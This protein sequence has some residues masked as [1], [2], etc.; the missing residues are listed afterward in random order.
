MTPKP[1]ELIEDSQRRN[2]DMPPA[3]VLTKLC[4]IT[5]YFP[6]YLGD[7][8][9]L[10]ITEEMLAYFSR[11]KLK[12]T[13]KDHSEENE[14]SVVVFCGLKDDIDAVLTS[15][16]NVIQKKIINYN[17]DL[18]F[19]HENRLEVDVKFDITKELGVKTVK[20]KKSVWIQHVLKGGQF[21]QIFD[22]RLQGGAA[23]T[24]MGLMKSNSLEPIFSNK[25]KNAF[26]ARAKG[27]LD[28]DHCDINKWII[29]RICLLNDGNIDIDKI[30]TSNSQIL[31]HSKRSSS[32]FD[33]KANR[34]APLNHKTGEKKSKLNVESTITCGSSLSKK[35]KLP[36]PP[37]KDPSSSISTENLPRKKLHQGEKNILSK[38]MTDKDTSY[39]H[40]RDKTQPVRE[41]E[42]KNRVN[43]HAACGSMWMQHKKLFGDH[44]DTNCNC[45]AEMDKLVKN[46]VTGGTSSDSGD[47]V[48]FADSFC[49]K[50]FDKVQK[51]FPNNSA[52]QILLKLVD[53]WKLGHV[54]Q[55]TLGAMCDASCSCGN[56]WSL[57]FLPI[58]RGDLLQ[59]D[60]TKLSIHSSAEACCSDENIF[61]DITFRPSVSS[62]GFYC[63]THI[64]DESKPQCIVK[65]V[66]PRMKVVS[67]LTPGTIVDCYILGKETVKVST[68]QQLERV[69]NVLKTRGDKSPLTIRFKKVKNSHNDGNY[70]CSRDWSETN[71]WI[72]ELSKQGW[73]GGAMVLKGGKKLNKGTRALAKESAKALRQKEKFLPQSAK[74]VIREVMKGSK[75][76]SL[77]NS[78]RTR[79]GQ[80]ITGALVLTHRDRSVNVP[81][82]TFQKDA[83]PP[84]SGSLLP[85]KKHS[86]YL[87]KHT[88]NSSSLAIHASRPL[89]KKYVSTSSM[90]PSI[91]KKEKKTTQNKSRVKFD[92]SQ[93]VVNT[94]IPDSAV[95]NS[96]K[97]TE[98]KYSEEK[99][100]ESIMC[101]QNLERFVEMLKHCVHDFKYESPLQTLT[102]RIRELNEEKETLTT[103]DLSSAEMS[104]RQKQIDKDLYQFEMKKKIVKIYAK[105][106]QIL[107]TIGNSTPDVIK[108]NI[109]EHVESHSVEITKQILTLYDWLMRFRDEASHAGISLDIDANVDVHG[110]SLAHAAV[111]VGDSNLLQ[112]LIQGGAQMKSSKCLGTPYELCQFLLN[113]ALMK[114][115]LTWTKKYMKVISVLENIRSPN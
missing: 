49:P 11:P 94:Y 44:C 31:H 61:F 40:F 59:K 51:Y 28:K 109:I 99:L 60:D 32:R 24:S 9:E 8:N 96:P 93:N 53:M 55:R 4:R 87:G 89:T 21:D 91:L 68:H 39:R 52:E 77:V 1:S 16:V 108:V 2:D 70:D 30:V 56:L 14:T 43:G 33:E 112:T 42:F 19:G 110:V 79:S 106:H 73:A 47:K 114:G 92:F 74:E 90:I 105:A 22:S 25:A 113:Q 18:L 104:E 36:S 12:I 75:N 41:I 71:S 69:Y 107:R 88:D 62:L 27:E 78:N 3:K 26:L 115:N 76:A 54:K 5:K 23:I 17:S 80:G 97:N 66:D 81:N 83:K 15:I 101:G 34:K 7:S 46:I 98:M 57:L 48:G 86:Q 103:E 82:N 95:S 20:A 63:E 37:S 58:C 45:V 102:D 35:R 64:C 72:G 100:T 10:L 65:S 85:P 84:L 6:K 38:A 29:V 111:F 13:L 67:K 50:F